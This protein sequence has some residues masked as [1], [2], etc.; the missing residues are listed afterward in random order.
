MRQP[1]IEHPTLALEEIAA[2]AE[3]AFDYTATRT[4]LVR[5]VDDCWERLEDV[6]SELVALHGIDSQAI[7]HAVGRTIE[8]EAATA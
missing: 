8:L 3:S 2:P 7:L 5:R 6:V 4:A 1:M